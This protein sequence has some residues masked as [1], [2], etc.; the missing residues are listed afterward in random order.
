MRQS[1]EIPG[2]G[3]CPSVFSLEDGLIALAVLFG[4]FP[5]YFW[6]GQ[7][8]IIFDSLYFY[9]SGGFSRT[10]FYLDSA[11]FSWMLVRFFLPENSSDK[12]DRGEV[13]D[14]A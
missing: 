3:S 7:Y 14:D 10:L 9:L 2:S 6:E 5:V 8:K 1:R 13:I 12:Q 11:L 4:A